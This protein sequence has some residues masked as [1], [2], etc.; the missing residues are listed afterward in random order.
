MTAPSPNA[1]RPA[2]HPG[3]GPKPENAEGERKTT[4]TVDEF[5]ADLKKGMAEGDCT[6][7]IG[8]ATGAILIDT[9]RATH[10]PITF[11]AERRVDRVWRPIQFEQAAADIGLDEHEA[12]TI[13]NAADWAAI[14]CDRP[15]VRARILEACGLPMEVTA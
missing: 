2:R 5:F 10:C 7:R 14:C 12:L 6:A 11:V 15:R 9:P 13:V 8:D 3:D 1:A 4:M